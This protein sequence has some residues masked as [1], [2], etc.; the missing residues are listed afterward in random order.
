MTTPKEIIEALDLIADYYNPRHG[1][2]AYRAFDAI[3]EIF[4][5]SRL[6]RPLLQW[7]ITGYSHCL[8]QTW[9]GDRPVITLHPSI[10]RPSPDIRSDRNSLDRVWGVDIRWTGPVYAFDVLLHESIHVAQAA[11]HPGMPLRPSAHNCRSWCDEV[12]RIAP[13][14]GMKGVRADLQV[15]K[16][17]PIPGV[18]TKRGKPKTKVEKVDLGDP[19]LSAHG[20]FPSGVREY[21]GSAKAYYLARQLPCGITIEDKRVTRS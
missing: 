21:F 7:A 6:P 8:G 10:L 12:N 2:W 19:P 14:L 11:L 18:F 3:N 17:V 5:D 20:R 16:R 13:L 15:P 4:F 1:R 9:M